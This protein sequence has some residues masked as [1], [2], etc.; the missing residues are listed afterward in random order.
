MALLDH[1]A[2][3]MPGD[4]ASPAPEVLRQHETDLHVDLQHFAGAHVFQ[5]G[6]A[7]SITEKAVHALEYVAQLLDT[8]IPFVFTGGTAAQLFLDNDAVRLSRD[9]DV[10]ALGGSEQDWTEVTQRIADRFDGQVYD[11]I[12]DERDHDGPRPE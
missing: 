2:L 3:W 7:A 5:A 6:F 4:A 9:V 12:R 1:S 11:P 8:T 10:F